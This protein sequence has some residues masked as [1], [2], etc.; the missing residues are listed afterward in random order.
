MCGVCL[1]YQGT[2]PP[3]TVQRQSFRGELG[4]WHWEW[5]KSH[6]LAWK[7]SSP[8]PCPWNI[9]LYRIDKASIFPGQM[10]QFLIKYVM[11]PSSTSDVTTSR[12]QD[13]KETQRALR[14][15]FL[16]FLTVKSTMASSWGVGLVGEMQC[17]KKFPRTPLANW[18]GWAMLLCQWVRLKVPTCRLYKRPKLPHRCYWQWRIKHLK[19]AS[20]DPSGHG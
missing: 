14:R 19:V 20:I 11:K 15:L 6:K 13:N 16:H 17:G 2:L 18:C 9:F 10:H 7:L 4:W 3:P 12:S 8:H 1:F 5:M